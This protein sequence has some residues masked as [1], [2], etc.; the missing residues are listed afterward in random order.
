MH[1]MKQFGPLTG[2]VLIAV[3]FLLSGFGKL[4][5]I[6]ATT[7]YIASK[8]LP[9]ASV[10]AVGAGVLELGGGLLLVVGYKTRWVAF[11]LALFTVTAALIFHNFWAAPVDQVRNQMV[12]FLKNI[13][14]IGGMLYVM[15]YGS[16]PLALDR[17][18][19]TV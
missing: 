8:G 17:T 5:G 15:T 11:A 6:A 10:L 2:R 4:T 3:I 1:L 19:D 13:S 16:G 7:A 9:A 14:I 18:D 12:H